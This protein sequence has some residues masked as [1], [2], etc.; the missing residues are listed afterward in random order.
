MPDTAQ[1]AD[2]NMRFVSEVVHFQR[3]SS[4]AYHCT[5]LVPDLEALMD[6]V[7]DQIALEAT[8]EQLIV[9]TPQPCTDR[10]VF[11]ASHC[12]NDITSN[13]PICMEVEVRGSRSL[14][15]LD[16]VPAHCSYSEARDLLGEH[17]WPGMVLR[18]GTSTSPLFDDDSFTALPGMLVRF[19]L[20]GRNSRIPLSRRNCNIR[21][22]CLL[23]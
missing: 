19:E 9:V 18:A 4:F 17:F 14:F 10:P 13:V 20:S 22:M 23:M 1:T 21:L 2:A 12:R 8:A 15:W 7:L 6:D 11:I 3:S 16:F 5:S